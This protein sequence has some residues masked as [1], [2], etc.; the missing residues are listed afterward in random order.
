MKE[1]SPAPGGNVNVEKIISYTFKD[2]KLLEQAFTH[3]SNDAPAG[4]HNE[5]LE[6]LGDSILSFL[7]CENLYSNLP[8]LREGDLTYIKSFVVSRRTLSRVARS[9][10]LEE[11]VVLGKG[12]AKLKRLPVSVSA[13]VYEALLA[14]IYL[15][16]GIRPARAFALRT[17]S[18]EIHSVIENRHPRNYKSLLQ[19]H[20]QKNMDAVPVYKISKEEGPD[21]LKTFEAVAMIGGKKFGHGSGATKKDAEQNAAR[22]TLE[23]IA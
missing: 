10:G 2:K 11:F 21:H 7:I 14:A 4:Y 8:A 19:Q 3:P 5:R 20:T 6:F 13:N 15:D 9:M 12:M 1:P 18:G 22:N 16:G 23:M 17:L